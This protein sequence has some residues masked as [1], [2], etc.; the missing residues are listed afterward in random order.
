MKKC[1][2]ILL[3]SA[4]SVLTL[5]SQESPEEI[6][7]A[8]RQARKEIKGWESYIAEMKSK[9]PPPPPSKTK[10]SVWKYTGNASINF[11]ENVIGDWAAGGLSSYG[12]QAIVHVEQD[13][14]SGKNEWD[15]TFDGRYGFIKN[16]D[17]VSGN[18]RPFYKSMDMLQ[19][20]TKY[21]RHLKNDKLS[22]GIEVNFISQFNKTYDVLNGTY[23]FS[24]FLSPGILDMSPGF[25]YDPFPYFRI[26]FAPINYRMKFV[27]NDT[28]ISRTSKF[29][30]RYGHDVN[31]EVTYELGSKIDA[32]FE[33]ELFK[34]FILRSRLQLI[35]SWGRP[36][37]ILD[38]LYSSR[39][40]IDV[41]WQTD[42][43]YKIFKSLSLQAGFQLIHDD[44]HRFSNVDNPDP[45]GKKAVWQLRENM[46]I[47]LVLG[48]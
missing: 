29:A 14:R 2:I 9:L 34:G 32:L 27:T 35:N 37:P 19:L 45:D 48:I 36:S 13:L 1:F 4:A 41:Y 40:N 39:T 8:I 47:G 21:L 26:F 28:I 38:R 42:L 33:K 7:S 6:D 30:N 23:L 22:L 25:E 20:N 43:F 18:T 17:A 11:S 24:D 10:K 12:F 31:E 3:F 5:S 16:F 46:G 15:N 44:D